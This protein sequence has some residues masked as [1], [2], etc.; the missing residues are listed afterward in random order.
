MAGKKAVKR[1]AVNQGAVAYDGGSS[2]VMKEARERKSGG[3]ANGFKKGGA[4]EL[5]TGGACA[6]P[7]MD[8]RATGGRTAFASGGRTGSDKNPFSSAKFKS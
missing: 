7:R 2:N 3:R 8:K 4:V 1:G 5:K 6:K